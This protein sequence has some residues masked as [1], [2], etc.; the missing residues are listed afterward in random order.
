MEKTKPRFKTSQTVFFLI[1]FDVIVHLD[2][3]QVVPG[4]RTD[5]SGVILK[6]DFF[7]KLGVKVSGN[8]TTH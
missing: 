4:Y 8:L 3:C 5:P 2:D 1:N 7:N 6:L